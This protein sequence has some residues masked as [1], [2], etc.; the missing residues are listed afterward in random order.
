MN[1]DDVIIV[2]SGPDLNRMMI[3][4]PIRKY[5]RRIILN[6]VL[7]RKT[8]Y[9]GVT[10]IATTYN[11]DFFKMSASVI[12]KMDKDCLILEEAPQS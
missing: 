5:N 11:P 10:I 6:R 7:K 1:D 2:R 12:I 4:K 3:Q 9:D 8:S